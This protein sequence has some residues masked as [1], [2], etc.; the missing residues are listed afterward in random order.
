MAHRIGTRRDLRLMI[1]VTRREMVPL[2]GGI[3]DL[4]RGGNAE[5]LRVERSEIEGLHA[6]AM[7]PSPHVFNSPAIA[8]AVFTFVMHSDRGEPF[9]TAGSLSGELG[10]RMGDG[11]NLLYPQARTPAIGTPETS[12]RR[13]F[14]P[15]KR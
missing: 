1:S 14:R 11:R 10:Y 5:A 4:P 15:W 7:L 12:V 6:S 13:N 8:A 9:A 2:E 3:G